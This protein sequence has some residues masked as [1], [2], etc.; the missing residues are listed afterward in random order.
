MSCSVQCNYSRRQRMKKLFA[1][2]P[3]PPPLPCL[4]AA[5]LAPSSFGAVGLE[6]ATPCARST[7]RCRCG[8]EC[9]CPYTVLL[10]WAGLGRAGSTHRTV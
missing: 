1:P 10:C 4:R 8:L 5:R 7:C 2:L 3:S 9:R 6:T